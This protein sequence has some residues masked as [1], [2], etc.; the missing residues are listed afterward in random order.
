VAEREGLHD[1]VTS[2]PPTYLPLVD[3]I[4]EMTT[5]PGNRS[6]A[7]MSV[8][9]ALPASF[10]GR[11][12][13]LVQGRVWSIA[14]AVDAAERARVR[15]D[16]A[17]RRAERVGAARVSVGVDGDGELYVVSYT[18]GRIFKIVGPAAAPAAPSGLHIVR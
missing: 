17:H 3:P 1:N 7:A 16:R 6:P 9:A 10:K 12:C 15:A 14:L 18:L 4:F 2:R 5:R 8:A 11:Y 13:R